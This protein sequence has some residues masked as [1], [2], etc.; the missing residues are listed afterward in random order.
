MR[1]LDFIS[2]IGKD[3]YISTP[4]TPEEDALWPGNGGYLGGQG[5]VTALAETGDSYGTLEVTFADGMSARIREDTEIA[6]I[7]TPEPEPQAPT[8][9]ALA[10]LLDRRVTITYGGDREV[11]GRVI[12]VSDLP[13]RRGVEMRLAVQDKTWP[14]IV[15]L[16]GTET[17]SIG[18]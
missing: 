12:R 5:T 18:V 8:A 10:V 11:T 4:V 16:Y 15:N 13:H 14:E 6:H 2:L 9:L 1:A 7:S 17:Y 3:A